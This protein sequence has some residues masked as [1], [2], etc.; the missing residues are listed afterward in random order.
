VDQEHGGERGFEEVIGAGE[1]AEGA[2]GFVEIRLGGEIELGDGD[3][4]VGDAAGLG[5]AESVV[6]GEVEGGEVEGE[7]RQMRLR[8]GFQ[9]RVYPKRVVEFVFR[10]KV[11]DLLAYS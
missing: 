8:S 4:A 6:A 7:V 2:G 5:I 1:I 10:F 11:D 3:G 9:A